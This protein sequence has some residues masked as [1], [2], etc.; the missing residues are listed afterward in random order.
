MLSGCYTMRNNKEDLWTLKICDLLKKELDNN[1]YEVVCFEKIPYSVF[2]NSYSE[3][4]T[5]I[6]VKRYEVDLL[7]KEKRDTYSIP[8]LIIESKYGKI[9]THD[10]ITYSN[11]AKAHKDLYS[12]LRYGLMIGNSN[13]LGVS[14]RIV[15]H[16]N[17]F[18][19]MFVFKEDV[20]SDK[21]WNLFVNVIKRNLDISNKLENI[22]SGKN[23]KNKIRYS[24]IEKNIEFYE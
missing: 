6:D 4:N 22:I 14:P 3:N 1:K 8:K 13:E 17:N 10:T 23:D 2:I 16:G 18:D 11:K 24:C 7:I 20:P 15:S 12:G 21:E 5:N 9:T 19:F